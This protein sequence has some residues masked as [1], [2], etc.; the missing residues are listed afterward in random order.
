MLSKKYL[1]ALTLFLIMSCS[2]NNGSGSG[3]PYLTYNL[4]D[5]VLY[6]PSDAV[7]EYTKKKYEDDCYAEWYYYCPPLDEVWRMKVTVDTCK[8][9]IVIEMG[10]CEEVLECIPTN[11]VIREEECVTEDGINGFLKVY[12]HKGYFEYGICDPCVEEICDGI[13]NDCDGATDEGDYPCSTECGDGTGL[14]VEG[15]VVACDAPQPAEEVC[16]YVD[17]DCDDLI[18]EGQLNAC[19]MCGPIPEEVCDGFDNDCNGKTDEGLIEKCNTA[20]EENL[21]VC[22]NG[23]WLCT[24]QQPEEEV[25]NGQDDDCD[26]LVDEELLCL[27]T[28]DQIGVLYPCTEPPLLCGQGFKTCE[29]VT[30]ECKALQMSPCQA[31][32]T[33]IPSAGPVPCD[34]LVGQIIQNEVCNNHDENCNQLIDEGLVQECYTGPID[35]LNIGICLPGEMICDTGLWGN[36]DGNNDFV[37]NLCLDEKTPSDKDAC[38]GQDDNCDG[39]IDDGKEMQDTDIIFVVDG[40]GSMNDEINGVLAALSIFSQEFADQTA[41][42]WGFI[43]APTYDSSFGEKALLISDL[44]PFDDFFHT[45]SNTG[46]KTQ[47]GYEMLYDMIYLLMRG[48]IPEASMPYP[49]SDLQWDPYYYVSSVPDLQNFSVSWRPNVNHVII[50]FTDEE[51]QSYMN[52][53]TLSPINGKTAFGGGYITQSILLGLIKQDPK[54]SIYTFTPQYY[55]NSNYIGKPGG[56]EPVSLASAL[57]KWYELTNSATEIY[58]YLSEILSETAC[59]EEAPPTP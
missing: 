13:D 43:Y 38:N 1:F 6:T 22:V 46:F 23:S 55:K 25:C 2:N 26:G 3:S 4:P 59:G 16:D 53:P 35:T 24:A 18:D 58:A 12:C 39:L 42:K 40:S 30:E 57:G 36:Y 15:E 28:W 56:W 44:Q 10:E 11:E 37:P 7:I 32:C 54:L 52:S 51:G 17:N 45:L 33:Y 5:A 49:I 50:V 41:V 34:P 48:I 29:C 8:D 9:N 14:C 27:C 31:L 19:N 47:G 20:C 21:N